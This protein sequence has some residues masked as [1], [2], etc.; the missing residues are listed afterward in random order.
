MTTV[1]HIKL[2]LLPLSS[3]RI[4]LW[5]DRAHH[6]HVLGYCVSPRV[7]LYIYFC[8]CLHM[9]AIYKT[10]RIFACVGLSYFN[11]KCAAPKKT[12]IERTQHLSHISYVRAVCGWLFCDESFMLIACDMMIFL[13]HNKPR[14]TR[15]SLK[16]TRTHLCCY[17][18]CTTRATYWARRAT[19][20]HKT[21]RIAKFSPFRHVCWRFGAFKLKQVCVTPI[22]VSRYTQ[23]PSYVCHVVVRCG[24]EMSK[25]YL[26]VYNALAFVS[27]K[28][29]KSNM[30]ARREHLGANTLLRLTHKY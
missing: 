8:L 10:I 15:C 11:Y 29:H 16:H 3:R 26:C 6:Q 19:N 28:F 9:P 30:S 23:F 22:I 27:S 13:Q 4:K 7:S 5:I 20:K 21:T 2:H 12:R 24:H 14:H 25:K 1:N 17:D 18:L